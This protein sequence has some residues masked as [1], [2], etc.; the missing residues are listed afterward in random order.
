MTPAHPTAA[1]GDQG[2]P[3]DPI[4]QLH[5]ALV[6]DLATALD[7]DAGAGEAT[8]AHHYARLAEDLHEILDLDAGLA[9]IVGA[10]GP[11][12]D[13]VP[14]SRLKADAPPPASWVSQLAD[15]LRRLDPPTR[16]A[17]RSD[18]AS[19]ALGEALGLVLTLA[20]AAALA[21]NVG[22]ARDRRGFA[23]ELTRAG[24]LAN[25]LARDIDVALARDLVRELIFEL[26]RARGLDIV[27]VGSL[28][29]HLDRAYAHS[30]LL[31]DATATSLVRTLGQ[32]MTGNPPTTQTTP[33]HEIRYVQQ[34][35]DH[36]TNDFVGADLER[37]SLHG[38]SL[39][40]IRWS[41]STRWPADWLE[42]IRAASVE[43]EPGI[44]QITS[45]GRP[46][47]RARRPVTT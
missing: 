13:V 37:T 35:L 4:A 25:A 12:S 46:E 45:W 14:R 15:H 22:H 2:N 24:D 42:R 1:A 34:V 18:K 44:F 16:L 40:G 30:C 10:S 11:P 6:D 39:E 33:P 28:A 26:D 27:L 29:F 43:V 5:R 31:V 7:L 9:E 19:S 21:R 38:A 47:Q 36:V 8:H 20:V 23:R 41:T 3:R 32:K 17:V